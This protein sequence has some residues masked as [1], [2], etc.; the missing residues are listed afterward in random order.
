MAMNMSVCQVFA[1]FR[2]HFCDAFQKEV[3]GDRDG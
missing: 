3:C 2:V 1:E